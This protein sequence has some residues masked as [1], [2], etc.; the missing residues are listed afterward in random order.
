[1]VVED[2][3]TPSKS[4]LGVVKR[5]FFEMW[6]KGGQQFAISEVEEYTIKVCF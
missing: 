6:D 1:M 3:K 2:I 5:F 4:V